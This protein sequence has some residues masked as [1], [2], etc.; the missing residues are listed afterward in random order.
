MHLQ[1]YYS[2][3]LLILFL[4]SLDGLKRT[5]FL[6]AITLFSLV[7]GFLPILLFFSLI[8]NV[9]KLEILIFLF[10]FKESKIIS[11][12]SSKRFSEIFF[13]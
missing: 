12:K 4:S 7:F 5:T 6:L 2:L 1:V 3:Y 13:E 8:L 10:F 11:K 9:P